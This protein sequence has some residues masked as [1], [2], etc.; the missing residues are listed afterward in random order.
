MDTHRRSNGSTA[1]HPQSQ[2]TQSDSISTNPQIYSG[3]DLARFATQQH[4]AISDA[5][6]GGDVTR[7]STEHSIFSSLLGNVPSISRDG[8]GPV[9]TNR[10]EDSDTHDREDSKGLDAADPGQSRSDRWKAKH[11]AMLK[12]ASGPISVNDKANSHKNELLNTEEKLARQQIFENNSL[13]IT[14]NE[15]T[16]ENDENIAVNKQSAAT[17]LHPPLPCPRVWPVEQCRVSKTEK[18][19]HKVKYI[20]RSS[21]AKSIDS[22]KRSRKV[23]NKKYDNCSGSINQYNTI[24]IYQNYLLNLKENPVVPLHYTTQYTLAILMIFILVYKSGAH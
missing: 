18:S 7:P 3:V 9:Q 4:S 1:S 15:T 21:K 8:V 10:E 6:G 20:E 14:L 17:G 11:E 13:V 5:V 2:P 19:Q 12:L 16:K 23:N 22:K 24:Q